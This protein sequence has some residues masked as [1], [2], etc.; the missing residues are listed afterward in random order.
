MSV[1]CIGIDINTFLCLYEKKSKQCLLK[2][3]EYDLSTVAF[4]NMCQVYARE[5]GL[6]FDP[7]AFQLSYPSVF[8]AW[9][10]CPGNF[11]AA[12]YGALRPFNTIVYVSEKN[13]GKIF[14]QR[15]GNEYSV[16]INQALS[17]T[18]QS[19]EEGRKQLFDTL[20]KQK[21]RDLL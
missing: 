11:H 13:G 9:H 2:E 17:L 5:R 15:E 6:S 16:Y 12:Y 8:G 21:L 7:S 4:M 1:V 19:E 14:F 18:A 10:L 3:Y 20:N